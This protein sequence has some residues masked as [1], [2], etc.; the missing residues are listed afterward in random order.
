[1]ENSMILTVQQK[2]LFSE[3]EALD[4]DLMKV[5]LLLQADDFHGLSL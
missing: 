4:L 5:L 1:M 3:I 2:S